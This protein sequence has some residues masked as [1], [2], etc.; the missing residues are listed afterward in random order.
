MTSKLG[1][2]QIALQSRKEKKRNDIKIL[3]KNTHKKHKNFIKGNTGRGYPS[4][5][6]SFNNLFVNVVPIS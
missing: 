2:I 5:H 3:R 6:I 1:T 4:G